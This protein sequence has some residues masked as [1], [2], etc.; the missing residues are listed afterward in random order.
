MRHTNNKSI[1]N[2]C[3]AL[4]FKDNRQK[5]RDQ[6]RNKDLRK[7]NRISKLE[8][9]RKST[10]EKKITVLAEKK[11]LTKQETA[12]LETLKDDLEFMIKNNIGEEER[13]DQNGPLGENSI[14]YD[15]EWNPEGVAP[16]NCRNVKYNRATFVRRTAIKPRPADLQD[17]KLP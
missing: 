14:F 16:P 9:V 11:T 8:K 3:I 13:E 15:S 6:E 4:L 2:K 7:R 10:L 5:K 12:Q 17:I 1:A